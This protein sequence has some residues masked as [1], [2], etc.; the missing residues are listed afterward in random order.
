MNLT[1]QTNS[2]QHIYKGRILSLRVDEVTLPNGAAA[3]REV[4]EHNGGVCVL[5]LTDNDE[6]LLVQQFRY[7]YMQV[8]TELPAGKISLGEDPLECGKRELEEETGARA[9]HYQSLGVMYPTPG[10][11][12]EVI[13]MYLATGLSFGQTHPDDDEFL[14]V[15]RVPLTE[16]VQQ[17]LQ[18]LVPDAKT[19]IAVLKLACMRGLV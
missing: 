18:G 19:Q 16:L 13:H 11:C 7:P 2:Q 10:Y 4:I 3:T 9:A 17:V 1:E 5:A 14:Q 12:G 8:L 15:L 6:V